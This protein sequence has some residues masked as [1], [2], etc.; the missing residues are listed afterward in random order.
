MSDN[1]KFTDYESSVDDSSYEEDTDSELEKQNVE[2][3][4]D[5][6]LEEV[7]K[8]S[9]A[10]TRRIRLW[11]FFLVLSLLLIAGGASYGTYKFLK[12]QEGDTFHASVRTIFVC[13]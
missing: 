10:D 3:E 2:T 5:Q 7:Q 6:G 13:L 9:R 8:L 4:K 11:R 12:S 1:Q